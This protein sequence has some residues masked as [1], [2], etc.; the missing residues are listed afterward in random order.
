MCSAYLHINIQHTGLDEALGRVRSPLENLRAEIDELRAAAAQAVK[1]L[2]GK[3][4]E[5][6]SILSAHRRLELLLDA[7][8]GLQRM[9]VC[10]YIRVCV[11]ACARARAHVRARA[12]AR[13]RVHVHVRM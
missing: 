8:Q 4:N 11:C 7:E 9:E 1:Q 3:L 5:R 6:Q 10:I 13:A 2:E 12:R